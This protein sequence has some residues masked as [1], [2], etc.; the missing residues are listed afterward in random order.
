MTNGTLECGEG[1]AKKL[2]VYSEDALAGSE[3]RAVGC[4]ETISLRELENDKRGYDASLVPLKLCGMLIILVE[5]GETSRG[6]W[7]P[8]GDASFLAVYTNSAGGL[9]PSC[10]R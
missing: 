6:V 8:S 3:S 9:S 10:T 4:G 2:G 5:V 7:R 1:G